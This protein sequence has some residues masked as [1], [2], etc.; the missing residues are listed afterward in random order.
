[1]M[2]ATDAIFQ[3]Q[4]LAFRHD[5]QSAMFMIDIELTGMPCGKKCEGAVKGCQAEAG[6][7]WGSGAW[8]S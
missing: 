5:F 7:R 2:Q 6:I 3:R 4:S 1:M 8:G